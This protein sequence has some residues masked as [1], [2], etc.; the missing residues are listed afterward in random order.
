MEFANDPNIDY[1]AL[2]K[3]GYDRCAGAYNAARQR[4]A[5]PELALVS[6]RLSE[7]AKILDI[8]CGAGA[9]IAQTLSQHFSVTGVDI[10]VEQIRLARKHVPQG[11]FIQADIMTMDFPQSIFDA[12]VS[13]YAI[14]HVPREEHAELFR[15]IR[16]WIKSGGYLLTTVAAKDEMPYTEDD[17]YGVKMYWS[18]YGFDHYCDLLKSVGFELL[19]TTTLGHGYTDESTRPTEQHPLILAIAV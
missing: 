12:I 6:S 19:E 5:I 14:F 17:F 18:S 10:S 15:R 7:G 11:D 9:P 2:V 1:K 16:R 4:E 13:F 8:G 3:Q